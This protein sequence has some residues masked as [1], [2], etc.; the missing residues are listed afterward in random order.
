MSDDRI[1]C[2]CQGI[3]VATIKKAIAEGAETVDDIMEST[4]AG[5]VCG[6]CIDEIAEIIEEL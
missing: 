4:G 2:A 1:I 3:D 5:T 6:A